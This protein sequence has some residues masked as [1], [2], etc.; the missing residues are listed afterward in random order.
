MKKIFF[1]ITSAFLLVGCVESI[2]LLG[3]GATNGKLIQSSLKSVASYGVKKQTGKTP[4][5][6]FLSQNKEKKILKKENCLSF[7]NKDLEICK[8]VKKRIISNQVEIKE[9]KFLDKPLKKT[10]LSLQSSI[11]EKSKIKYLD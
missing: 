7:I 2:A 6:H 11:N 3:G 4:L 9:K 1:L 10:T 8:M 5:Q